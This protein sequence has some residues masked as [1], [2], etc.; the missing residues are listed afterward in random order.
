MTRGA[1]RQ[2]SQDAEAEAGTTVAE[3]VLLLSTETGDHVLS[4][5]SSNSYSYSSVELPYQRFDSMDVLHYYNS[6]FCVPC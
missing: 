2:T 4:S 5:I 3:A 1:S 6:G